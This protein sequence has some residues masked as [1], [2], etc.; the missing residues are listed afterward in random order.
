M[1]EFYTI[2]DSATRNRLKVN[3][4]NTR[5]FLL[6]YSLFNTIL[7]YFIGLYYLKTTLSSSSLFETSFYS[8]QTLIG[9]SLV[10]MFTLMTYLGHFALLA[11]L[12]CF[13]LFPVFLLIK[14]K[15]VILSVSA[16]TWSIF[17]L[18]LLTDSILFSIF[19]FH[20]NF[21]LLKIL[22]HQGM[23]ILRLT[24]LSSLEIQMLMTAFLTIVMLEVVGAFLILKIDAIGKYGRLAKN[25]LFSLLFCLMLSYITFIVTTAN[26]NNVLAQQTPNFPLYNQILSFLLPEKNSSFIINQ[27]SETRFSQPL[28][29]VASVK[30]PLHA[31]QCEPKPR[32]YNILIIGIDTWRHDAF[33]P[34]L[35]PHL[36][37]LGKDSWIFDKHMSGGNSTQAGLFSLFY[38][39]SGNYWSSMME[40]R[41]GALLIDEAIK[42]QFDTQILFSSVMNPPF[43]KSIF[44]NLH[45]LRLGSASGATIPDHDRSITREFQKFISS[46][47]S[48]KPFFTFLFYDAAHGYY[49]EQNIPAIYPVSQQDEQRFLFLN[50][51][52]KVLVKN[53]YRNAVHFIDDEINKVL[54]ALKDKNLL[55]NTIVIVTSDHGEEFDDNRKSYW[56]HG[57]N[58]TP[59]QIQV[60]LIIRWP[61]QTPHHWSHLTSHYDI[62]PY[63]MSHNF[64][65]R[66]SISD[67]SIGEGL[68]EVHRQPFLLVGSYINMCIVEPNQN[69]TLLTSGEIVIAD[70]QANILTGKINENILEEALSM[71]RKYYH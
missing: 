66:N 4:L 12:P 6:I 64:G 56:G 1:R 41:Q 13:I 9:K 63:V 16:A 23:Q 70:N 27:L 47:D 19:H 62:A 71:M 65:C 17:S 48:S 30:Y 40:Y 5:T 67:Y 24:T 58:Y 20:L 33:N 55:D 22:A 28:F 49:S 7:F 53:R 45:N 18:I 15:W 26:H 61:G 2:N 57:S 10:I 46:R 52:N 43:N 25:M 32:P 8:Y 54:N 31:L 59:V 44:I 42:Q 36:F 35:T 3:T 39:L 69:T 37:Q 60:P 11:F 68:L 51:K 29:P 34:Q 14:N 38:G 50:S 21:I